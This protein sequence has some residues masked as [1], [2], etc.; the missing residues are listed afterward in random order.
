MKIKRFFAPDMRQ[1]I[2]KVRETQGPD[3]VIL[4][5]RKVEGGVEIVAAIDYDESVVNQALQQRQDGRKPVTQAYTS[6]GSPPVEPPTVNPLSDAYASQPQQADQAALLRNIDWDQDPTIAQMQREIHALREL[7]ENQVAHLTWG[8]LSRKRPVR[9]DLLRRLSA[10]GLSEDLAIRLAETADAGED[11]EIAWR[12][13]LGLFAEQLPVT[14][15]DIVSNGG[16]VA[17]VGSTGVGKTTTVAKLVARFALRH[18]A[19]NVAL[20]T[21]DSYRIGA[22]EQLFT[23]G[24]IL[25]V[26]VQVASNHIELQSALQSLMDKRLVLIDT[27]GMSQ[28]DVRLS[29]QFATLREAG[30]PIKSFLAMAATTETPVLNEAINTF[31]GA[32]LAGCILTKVDE[33]A[34]LGD[35]L[36]LAAQQQLPIAYVGDG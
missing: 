22:H 13:A 3:A 12:R 30:M 35:T 10:L 17:L 7:L 9:A 21:T 25:G 18:G 36:A 20:V 4:S 11:A 32:G 5:N 15:D 31:S 6:A 2:Q 19:R 34:C 24:R 28:R 16:I 1:A 26:P 23:Y 27:A 29:E 8:E 14:D 33:A